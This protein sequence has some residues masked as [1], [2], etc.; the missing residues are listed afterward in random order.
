MFPELSM[1]KFAAAAAIA[2]PTTVGESI[3]RSCL[4]FGM[5]GS[6]ALAK[7]EAGLLTDA[8]RK[9]ISKVARVCRNTNKF[10]KVLKN[11]TNHMD[12]ELVLR[13]TLADLVYDNMSSKVASRA[14]SH[15][16][17]FM[18]EFNA[19]TPERVEEVASKL[20]SLTNVDLL[21]KIADIV[22]DDG[23]DMDDTDDDG[24]DVEKQ[25]AA[26]MKQD[27]EEDDDD[28]DDE[29]ME[30]A[31]DI[32][33]NIPPDVLAELLQRLNSSH[34]QPLN[35]GVGMEQGQESDTAEVARQLAQMGMG[36][37]QPSSIAP[38]LA[39]LAMSGQHA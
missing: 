12:G 16:A 1:L 28:E 2:E 8:D 26:R 13:R 11:A 38:I 25:M 15:R 17:L 14:D 6:L 27:E 24:E 10:A 22:G 20:A 23:A 37:E 19:L 4:A 3:E 30:G 18:K 35:D 29:D 5:L 31:G 9:M 34:F 39:A 33:G 7:K 36:D 21:L 32:E